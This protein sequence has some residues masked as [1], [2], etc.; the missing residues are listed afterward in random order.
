MSSPAPWSSYD[1]AGRA[2]R[3]LASVRFAVVAY[4]R[5]T[6]RTAFKAAVTAP[7]NVAR[8]AHHNTPFSK[9]LPSR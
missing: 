6:S 4:T 3:A 8:F 1:A 9:P 2:V 7:D 5:Y